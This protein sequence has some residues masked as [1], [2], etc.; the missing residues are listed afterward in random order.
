[1]FEILDQPYIFNNNFKHN[2]KTI[3]IVSVGLVLILLYFQPFGINFLA[4]SEYGYFVL[5]L[6]I[7][8][9]VLFFFN[10][11]LLPGLLP[12]IFN[13]DRWTIRK[14]IFWNIW[15]FVILSAGFVLF[16]WLYQT[17]F[18][19][20][21]PMFKIGALAMLPVVL[22]NIMNYNLLLKKRVVSAIDQKLLKKLPNKEEKVTLIADNG[23]DIFT[24]DPRNIILIRS[25]SNYIEIYWKD[26][27][28][29][30]KRLQRNTLMAA[31]N[32][33]KKYTNFKKC[34][35]SWVVNLDLVKGIKRNTQGYRLEIPGLDFTIPVSRS[36]YPF[37]RNYFSTNE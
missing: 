18:K 16:S 7:L 13:V 33:M 4:S 34:H 31:E 23:K 10:T 35:R 5:G 20:E 29:I 36:F 3:G 8:N 25:S 2:L 1:M 37:F 19:L 24:A 6:G 17:V 22:F 21:L 32:S 14:E 11:L 15:M 9:G 30:K 26:G 12:R 28:Q 27:N